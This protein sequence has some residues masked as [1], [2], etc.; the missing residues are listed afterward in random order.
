M[1][2]N[3]FL[4]SCFDEFF[5]KVSANSSVIVFL[6]VIKELSF[7]RCFI[8][9][10]CCL[11]AI[12]LII[13]QITFGLV[14][15]FNL[16]TQFCQHFLFAAFISLH[17]FALFSLYSIRLNVVGSF[18]NFFNA[19]FRHLIASRHLLLNQGLFRLFG[20][21][22]LGTQSIAMEFSISVKYSIVSLFGSLCVSFSLH[23]SLH[24]SQLA[25]SN[26]QHGIF[27]PG[28]FYVI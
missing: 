10:V 22:F 13:S 28:R 20:A 26:F 15:Q 23:F 16:L 21:A 6:S 5:E 19:T 11:L 12:L 18:W 2:I 4:P 7:Q 27:S 8:G 24:F 1:V 9:I 17:A 14:E 25:L 3:Y